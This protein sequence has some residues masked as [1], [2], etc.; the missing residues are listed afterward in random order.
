MVNNPYNSSLEDFIMYNRATIIS[1]IATTRDK[2]NLLERGLKIGEEVGELQRA[3]L[4]LNKSNGMKYRNQLGDEGVLEEIADVV[5]LSLS[6]LPYINKNYKD[7]LKM[8]DYKTIKWINSLDKED[9]TNAEAS[10]N[11]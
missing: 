10:S 3:I 7:L 2:K 9:N 4:I 11:D 8:I 1:E 6:M 5:M